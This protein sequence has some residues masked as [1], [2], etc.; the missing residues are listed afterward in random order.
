MLFLWI[1]SNPRKLN[2][3]NI[4]K[5]QVV[6]PS[7]PQINCAIQLQSS[8]TLKILLVAHST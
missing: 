7:D 6:I 3:H 1:T 5:A 4:Y 8:H 2:S